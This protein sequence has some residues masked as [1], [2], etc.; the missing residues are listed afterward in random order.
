MI[1][2]PNGTSLAKV[3]ID[4]ERI[5][6]SS[7]SPDGTRFAFTKE[8]D[9]SSKV[10][11]ANIDGTDQKMISPPVSGV[12]KSNARSPVWSPDGMKI[13][14]AHYDG[15]DGYIVVISATGELLAS[16]KISGHNELHSLTWSPDGSRIAYVDNYA[17][18]F[19]INSDGTGRTLLLPDKRL[20]FTDKE[21]V[22][23]SPDGSKLALSLA[24]FN[25]V[26]FIAT[27]NA[28]GTDLTRLTPL[29][30]NNNYPVWS[31]D[32]QYIAFVGTQSFDQVLYVMKADGSKIVPLTDRFHYIIDIS[33]IP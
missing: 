33:W 22:S 9:F 18:F 27:I 28:D 6:D 23:W 10:F 13:A 25:S 3:P 7:W 1:V 17:G 24:D 15:L 21:S 32:G 4:L 16:A 29:D 11:T 19:I 26:I 31:P 8:V 14:Y 2:K 12:R 20:T 30:G 5:S